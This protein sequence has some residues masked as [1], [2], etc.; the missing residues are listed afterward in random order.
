MEFIANEVIILKEGSLIRQGAPKAL[1]DELDGAVWTVTISS[2]TEQEQF[3]DV[4][5]SN[6]R[7]DENGIVLR[8]IAQDKPHSD[9][10]L[11]RPSLEDV[12]L[13]FFGEAGV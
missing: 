4:K 5:I 10:Q 2:D 11:V 7:R 9:A 3:A 13:S 12:F 6:M 1:E 8:L